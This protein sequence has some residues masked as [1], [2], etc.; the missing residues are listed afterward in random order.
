MVL[1]Q[2]INQQAAFQSH[3][4]RTRDIFFPASAIIL[5]MTIKNQLNESMKDAMRSGDE[6]RKQLS[7]K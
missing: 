7:G 5:P 4:L 6:V 1:E 2:D 3:S